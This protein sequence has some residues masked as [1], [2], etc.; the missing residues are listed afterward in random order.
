MLNTHW[1]NKVGVRKGGNAIKEVYEELCGTA[2]TTF[3]IVG[4]KINGL[5]K[6]DLNGGCEQNSTPLPS[7][8]V[9]IIANK[10]ALRYGALGNNLLN[11]SEK[12]IVVGKYINNSGA[13][14]TA[15]SNCYF[16][17]FIP[18]KASTEYS[19]HTS[20]SL[21]Y[22][23]FMEYDSNFEFVKRTLYGSANTPAGTTTVHTM[24][25]TT[26]YVK[27]GSNIN[28]NTL[29]ISDVQS[30]D[31]MFNE[32]SSA[33]A[34]EAYQ[35]GLIVDGSDVVRIGSKNLNEGVLEH[36]G[37]TSTGGI[38]AS[39]TFCGT[40]HK[41]KVKEGQKYTVSF[42]NFSNGVSGV[43]INTWLADG[44]WNARQAISSTGKLTYIIPNGVREVN[45]TLYKTGGITIDENSWM[46]VEYGSEATEYQPYALHGLAEAELLLSVGS[47]TDV[48]DMVKGIVTR[49]VGIKVFNGTEDGWLKG[50]NTDADGNSVF[51]IALNDRKNIDT[52][53]KLMSSHYSFR[54]TISYSNLKTGEMSIT[55]TTKNVYFDGGDLTA[56]A[57]W[58]SYL[59]GQYKQGTPVIVIYP[60]ADEVTESGKTIQNKD[61][62]SQV[63][64]SCEINSLEM[65]VCYLQKV[66]KPETGAKLITF[67]VDGV[68]YHT[69]EGMT[70]EQF[71][72]S[73]YNVDGFYEYESGDGEFYVSAGNSDGGWLYTEYL[74]TEDGMHIY[75]KLNDVIKE[76]DYVTINYMP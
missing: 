22:S 36:S 66:E 2:T 50:T 76:L 34:Y 58:K 61:G 19:L 27:I 40:L 39:T 5:T 62:N 32:G 46:Q 20:V 63:L 73:S 41:I 26:A 56:L 45:F 53:L 29:T 43:F 13:V 23:N 48:Q 54:G 33:L 14:T 65:N 9:A 55:Q 72:K 59:A 1:L 38:S 17:F 4:S 25:E 8:P 16:D 3:D 49:K 75:S 52:S 42:G 12:T 47:C 21:N 71:I 64:R 28:G 31:W 68:E 30:I 6:L 70:W 74:I 44:T 57:D 7:S 69:E 60:L 11:A 15:V 35:E 67:T 18:V 10:G 37:Y 24:S 51:Y